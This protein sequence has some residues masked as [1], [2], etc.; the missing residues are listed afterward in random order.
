MFDVKDLLCLEPVGGG[1]E[2]AVVSRAS[3]WWV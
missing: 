1:C 3:R 2:R